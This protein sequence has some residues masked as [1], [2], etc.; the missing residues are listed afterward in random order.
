MTVQTGRPFLALRWSWPIKSADFFRLLTNSIIR[1][2]VLW[3]DIWLILLYFLDAQLLI[4]VINHII[5]VTSYIF[6]CWFYWS[7]QIVHTCD[8]SITLVKVVKVIQV[9]HSVYYTLIMLPPCLF[10]WT[11]YTNYKCLRLTA[12]ADQGQRGDSATEKLHCCTGRSEHDAVWYKCH[13]CVWGISALPGEICCSFIYENLWT[14]CNTETISSCGVDYEV[15]IY[16]TCPI[17]L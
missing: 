12:G 16:L 14:F 3:L 7:T 5:V 2:S 8:I 11:A 1:Q 13:V 6:C 9:L 10:G 17:G 15:Q 4:T